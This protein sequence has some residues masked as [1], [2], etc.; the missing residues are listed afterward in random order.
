VC[1]S[2]LSTCTDTRVHRRPHELQRCMPLLANSV[3]AL[4]TALLQNVQA[5]GSQEAQPRVFAC[6]A[7]LGALY[8]A[9][10]GE[11]TVRAHSR[12]TRST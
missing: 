1:F 10:A 5:A 9:V 7:Q 4:A 3:R 11:G 2:L 8:A 6:A 12:A